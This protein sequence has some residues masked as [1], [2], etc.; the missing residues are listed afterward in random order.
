MIMKKVLMRYR[1]KI[2]NY[3]FVG[4]NKHYT[5]EKYDDIN[6][7]H[8]DAAKHEITKYKSDYQYVVEELPRPEFVGPYCSYCRANDHLGRDC[9]NKF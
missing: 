7:A 9:P 3:P 2:L 4:R 6:L 1:I 5:S 8:R